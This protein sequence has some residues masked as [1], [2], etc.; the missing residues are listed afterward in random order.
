MKILQR[1]VIDDSTLIFT[2]N[3]QEDVKEVQ[4]LYEDENRDCFLG[5]ELPILTDFTFLGKDYPC[6]SFWHDNEDVKE[7]ELE[8]LQDDK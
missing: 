4:K 8:A 7:I 5:Y 1:L 2:E 3:P 6:I